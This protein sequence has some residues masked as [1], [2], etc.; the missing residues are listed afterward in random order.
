MRWFCKKGNTPHFSSVERKTE[1]KIGDGANENPQKTREDSCSK[2]SIK[3]EG[4]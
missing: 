4:T 2:A 1:R 3:Q